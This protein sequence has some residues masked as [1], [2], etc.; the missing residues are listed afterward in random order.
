MKRLH[1]SVYVADLDEAVHFYSGL[2]GDQPTVLKAAYAK[3]SLADPPVNFAIEAS[4]SVKG[5]N[6][7]GI[8]AESEA[9]LEGIYEGFDASGGPVSDRGQ[10]HC[11]YAVSDK[12]WVR[13]PAGI[14]WE[15][16]LTHQAV[17]TY[18][19]APGSAQQT[20]DAKPDQQTGACC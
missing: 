18:G 8:E 16:F 11:C 5:L 2:F 12:G 10:S 7:L 9:E 4:K 13:D 17:D 19:S 14:A 1:V 15:G 20:A 6:H 3:W